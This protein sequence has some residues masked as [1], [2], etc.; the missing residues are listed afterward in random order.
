MKHMPWRDFCALVV[1]IGVV[2][3]G[4]CAAIFVGS[5]VWERKKGIV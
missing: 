2:G 1:S 5:A 4:L 3:L